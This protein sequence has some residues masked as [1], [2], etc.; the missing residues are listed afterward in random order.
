MFDADGSVSV[1][2]ARETTA[3]IDPMPTDPERWCFYA[4][5]E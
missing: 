5:L 4:V 1:I 3:K 2:P